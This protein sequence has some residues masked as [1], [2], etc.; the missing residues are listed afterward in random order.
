VKKLIPLVLGLSLM[1]AF[2][3]PS[4]ADEEPQIKTVGWSVYV[5]GVRSSANS[6]QYSGQDWFEVDQ[7]VAALGM[8]LQT[9]QQGVFVNGQPIKP[10]V[11]VGEVVYT[12]PDAVAQA[13]GATV[14]KDPVRTSLFFQLSNNNPAGIP[15]YSADYITP[16]EEYKRQRRADLAMAPGDAMLEEWDEKMAAEWKAK[17]PFTPY[18]PRAADYKELPYDST[19]EMPRLMSKEELLKSPTFK[20]EKPTAQPTGYLTRSADNGVFKVTIS[21]VKMAEALKGLKPPLM[22]QPGYKFLV[23]NLRLENVSKNRQRAGWFN[24]RDQNGTPYAANSLYSQ[25][26]QGEMQ[27]REITQGYLIFELPVSAQPVALEAL[28]TPAL[29]LSLIYR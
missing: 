12:T 9:S 10:V 14:Q 11:S 2:S 25:F 22:P 27:T 1:G 6:L 7:L 20:G 17:H 4:L 24:V 16:E 28:V 5:N 13:I 29:S 21:D 18:V 3:W 19:R 8:R 15:Y 23:V 26:S